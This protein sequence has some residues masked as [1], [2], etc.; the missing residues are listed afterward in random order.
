MD[1]RDAIADKTRAALLRASGSSSG[2]AAEAVDPAVAAK[3]AALKAKQASGSMS[4]GQPKSA[5]PLKRVFQLFPVLDVVLYLAVYALG[6]G[7][8]FAHLEEGWSLVDGVYY[9][10]VTGTSVGYGDLSPATAAGRTLA[11]VYLPFA[12]V[13]VSTQLSEVPGKLLGG[14]GSGNDAKLEKLMAADLSLEGLLAMDQDG[15]G[16][17]K[18]YTP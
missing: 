4:G 3:I 13:F 2:S 7:L 6:F 11:V 14:G 8:L 12:V 9:T 10:V 18:T 16:S 17:V 15:D 1:A 5:N